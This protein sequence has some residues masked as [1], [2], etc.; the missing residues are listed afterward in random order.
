LEEVM[1]KTEVDPDIYQLRVQGTVWPRG[2][3]S[4]TE[5]P[6]NEPGRGGKKSSVA[7]KYVT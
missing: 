5:Q 4:G 7:W 6:R 1:N 2:L 3:V